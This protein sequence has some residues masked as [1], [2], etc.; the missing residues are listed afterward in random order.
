MFTIAANNK[1]SLG[2]SLLEQTYRL[3][4]RQIVK[5]K[6]KTKNT[7]QINQFTMN[8]HPGVFLFEI[9]SSINGK[10]RIFI[11]LFLCCYLLHVV[12]PII[13]NL[14]LY[15][16][17][18]KCITSYHQQIIFQSSVH[19]YNILIVLSSKHGFRNYVILFLICSS[20]GSS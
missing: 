14:N 1:I 11:Y 4:T 9:L 6:R 13:V 10:I 12:L 20:L 3:V 17:L 7:I 16:S 19:Y 5:V 18:A 2:Q 15:L 8:Y